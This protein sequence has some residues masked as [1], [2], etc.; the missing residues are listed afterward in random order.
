MGPRDGLNGRKIS[1]PPGHFFVN[2]FIVLCSNTTQSVYS[3]FDMSVTFTS[4]GVVC[5]YAYFAGGFVSVRCRGLASGL[6]HS[7]VTVIC[8][9]ACIRIPH[10]PSRTTP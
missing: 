10:R 9:S 8:A 1:S 6:L 3:I 2:R 5:L 7:L 4:P